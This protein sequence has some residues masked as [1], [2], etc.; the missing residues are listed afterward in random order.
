MR[1]IQELDT[2]K[3]YAARLHATRA[4]PYLAAALFALHVVESPGTPTMAVDRHWRCY[5]SPAFV[6]QLPVDELASVWVHEVAHLLRDHHG[7]GDRYAKR[8]DLSG[9]GER[10]RMNIA[11]D[12]EIN[13]DAFGD[14]LPV[15]RGAVTPARLRMNPD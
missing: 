12:C 7:R 10:L 8:H 14:D 9:P 6:A 4:R 1:K 11:A 2:E 5:V 3:L 13:D 15:P